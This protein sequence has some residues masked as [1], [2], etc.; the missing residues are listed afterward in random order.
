LLGVT[1]LLS[2]WLLFAVQPMVAKRLLPW[3][4]GGT[5][6]WT[7]AML[8]FQAALLCGYL[9]VHL[10]VERLAPRAQVTFH[11]LLLA[12]AAGVVL[13][14]GVLPDDRWVPPT[15]AQPVAR[16]MLTLTA[17]AGIPYLA[18]AATAPLVQVWFAR[19]NAQG[20]PYRL[21]ALSNF[22]SLAAL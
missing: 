21:Y 17:C 19:A 16:I 13:A 2:A 8:F 20:A 3:F 6:I 1:A 4:G 11:I 14:I 9:Y 7:T 22:G 12:A 15:N 18:L 5:A 10:V